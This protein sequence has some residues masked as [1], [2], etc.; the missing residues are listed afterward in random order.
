MFERVKIKDNDQD[1]GYEQ[2]YR[3]EADS[4]EPKR[5]P[6]SQFGNEF[7]KH[8]R[9]CKQLV[10]KKELTEMGDT[11]GFNLLR[12]KPSSYS[13]SVFS[14]LSYEDLKKAHTETVVPVTHEDYLK[15]PQFSNIGSY[16]AYRDGQNTTPPSLEQS[17]QFLA[18]KVK[19]TSEGDVR[20]IYGIFKTG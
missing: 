5:I 8:K 16:R 7:E 4:K 10:V 1:S 3:S 17:R 2:W 14:K 6:F 18:E 13:S 9:E 20:R 11:K 15:K 19:T 12:E